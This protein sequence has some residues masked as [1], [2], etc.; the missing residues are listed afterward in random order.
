MESPDDGVNDGFKVV[1]DRQLRP[2]IVAA[3]NTE[4]Q[5]K[6]FQRYNQMSNKI[7]REMVDRLTEMGG[8]DIR[9][10]YFNAQGWV[11]SGPFHIKA[12]V[13]VNRFCELYKVEGVEF[14][15][16]QRKEL[17]K[18][19][20]EVEAL[21]A[22]KEFDDKG[23]TQVCEF[24]SNFKCLRI[25]DH[26]DSKFSFLKITPAVESKDIKKV[27]KAFENGWAMKNLIAK[28]GV[29]F[30]VYMSPQPHNKYD[31]FINI[32]PGDYERLFK[33]KLSAYKEPGRQYHGKKSASLK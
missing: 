6:E 8:K 26:E 12:H 13:T 9:T 20:S 15:E 22:R 31:L 21:D 18:R 4:V 19:S 7:I 14:N 24:A 16:D 30:A 25:A 29:G 32:D 33:I 17:E 27:I 3:S 2:V 10:V 11:R 28:P 1:L 5:R 23:T